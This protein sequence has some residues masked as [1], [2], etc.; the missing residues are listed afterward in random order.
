MYLINA[1]PAKLLVAKVLMNKL[2]KYVP[3]AKQ[4]VDS[5]PVLIAYNI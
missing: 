2:D 4:L 5:T 3:E 1:G